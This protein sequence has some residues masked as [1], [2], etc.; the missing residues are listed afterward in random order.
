MLACLHD[1][2]PSLPVIALSDSDDAEAARKLLRAGADDCVLPEETT[3]NTFVRIVRVAIERSRRSARVA[4]EA[5]SD[6]LTGLANRGCFVARLHREIGG[7][8]AET[9]LAVLY[10]DLDRFKWVNDELGHDMGDQLLQALSMKLLRGS[11]SGDL[12]ARLGGDKF[13]LLAAARDPAQLRRLAARLPGA[14][15]ETMRLGGV[16][17]NATI[18]VGVACHPRDGK[19]VAELLASADQAMDRAKVEGRNQ[20]RFA[21]REVG[22]LWL[23]FLPTP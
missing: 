12:V 10:L 1:A 3:R 18:S 2:M 17:V 20:Y 15:R 8:R 7:A 19:S 4:A 6:P 11:R 13:V 22:E 14:A 9:D 5:H 16:S 21:G 23:Q